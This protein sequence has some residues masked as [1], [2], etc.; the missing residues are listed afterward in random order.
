MITTKQYLLVTSNEE[1]LKKA[2]RYEGIRV[3]EAVNQTMSVWKL[4]RMPVIARSMLGPEDDEK[5]KQIP[6]LEIPDCVLDDPD[7]KAFEKFS[8]LNGF[9]SGE[10]MTGEVYDTQHEDCFLCRIGNLNGSKK[11]LWVYNKTVENEVDVIIME[12]SHFFVVPELGSIRKGYLMICPKEHILSMAELPDGYFAEYYQI[13]RDIEFILKSTYGFDQPVSFFEHGSD[14]NGK[15][16]HKR[17]VVHAHTH[18]CW[19]F[20]LSQKYMDM[21]Q[22]QWHKDLRE[23]RGGKYFSYRKNADG[24]LFF[25]NDPNVYVQRQFP[26]QVMAE[27]LGLAPGQYNWRHESFSEN[28]TATLYRIHKF[29]FEN[30]DSLPEH[31][32]REVSGFVK[33]YALRDDYRKV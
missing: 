29:L 17:S 8:H 9:E 28:V 19:G 1:R 5:H 30:F 4:N 32:Q 25:V 7:V 33:G 16:S 20:E 12:T 15:S 31:I 10:F 2:A 22:M 6:V 27:E 23:A 18:L 24:E 26:R 14:P 11:P 3:V 21:V 13:E